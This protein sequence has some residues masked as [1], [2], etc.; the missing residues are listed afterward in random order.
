MRIACTAAWIGLAAGCHQRPPFADPGPNPDA[1]ERCTNPLDCAIQNG[2]GVYAAEGGSASI[3]DS[4]LMIMHFINDAGKV[5]VQGRY[6][7]GG[8][9]GG[10][11]RWGILRELGSIVSADYEEF[12]N[13]RHLRIPVFRPGLVV[14][15]ITEHDT[16][17]TWLLLDPKTGSTTYVVGDDMRRLTLHLDVAFGAPDGA[18]ELYA[19]DFAGDPHSVP[20]ALARGGDRPIHSYP[21]RWTLEQVDSTPGAPGPAPYCYRPASTTAA[22]GSGSEADTVVFQAGIKVN[23]IS[24]KVTHPDADKAVAG[25]VTLSCYFGAPATVARW[26]Y[27]YRPAADHFY[28]DAA[29]QMKRASYCADE[30]AYTTAGTAIERSDSANIGDLPNDPPVDAGSIEAAW[31]PD[32]ARCLNLTHERHPELVGTF[33]GCRNLRLPSCHPNDIMGP[34]WIFDKPLGK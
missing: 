30:R 19:I 22:G 24:G 11:S 34:H 33:S 7:L 32:G 1:D 14:K 20:A 9:Q 3:G 2:I 15:S 26:G 16:E 23:P 4:R 12:T 29:I 8:P 31:T 10:S 18:R 6:A 27:D 5:R 25:M 13:V 17:P 28:F 21:M